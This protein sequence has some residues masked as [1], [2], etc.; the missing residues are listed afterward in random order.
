[1][2]N[3]PGTLLEAIQQ[4]S[5]PVAC[6]N[7]VAQLRWPNGPICPRCD[8]ENIAT[9]STRVG[10]WRCR[11]CQKQFSVKVGTIFEDSPIPLEKWAAAIWL[12]GNCKNGVSSCEIARDLDITQKSA[13]FMLHRIRRAMR[14]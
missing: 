10:M 6:L 1:M 4:F 11:A 7:F 5:D 14:T 3:A 13:W 8:S 12:L 2:A 9:I